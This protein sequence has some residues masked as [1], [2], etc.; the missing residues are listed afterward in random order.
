MPGNLAHSFKQPGV[1]K[2]SAFYLVSNHP[3]PRVLISVGLTGIQLKLLNID[4]D[5]VY[6][7]YKGL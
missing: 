3:I 7:Q 1:C 5:C 2:S 6:Y 4:D